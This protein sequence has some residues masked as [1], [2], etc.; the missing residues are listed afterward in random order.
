MHFAF[1]IN[2]TAGMSR[3]RVGQHIAGAKQRDHSRQDRVDVFTIGAA[4][5]QAPKLSE[6][7]IDRKVGATAL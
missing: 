4:L 3:E 1:A 7:H 6:V 5:R 2:K